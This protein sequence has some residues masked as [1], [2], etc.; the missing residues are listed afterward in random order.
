MRPRRAP[1]IVRFAWPRLWRATTAL[2]LVEGTGIDA[3]ASMF[4]QRRK[5]DLARSMRNADPVLHQTLMEERDKNIARRTELHKML[6]AED[7]KRQV[8]AEVKKAKEAIAKAAADERRAKR[9]RLEEI[10]LGTDRHWQAEDFGLAASFT[11]EHRANIR[12]ALRRLQ[13][14]SPTLPEEVQAVWKRFLEEWPQRVREKRGIGAGQYLL[15]R[16]ECVLDELGQHAVQNPALDTKKPR[17]SNP[18]NAKAFE[19]FVREE[20]KMKPNA[21]VCF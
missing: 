1:T 13:M 3:S 2:S 4:L 10:D 19:T 8:A 21:A 7:R 18:G 12:L 16:F 14:R 5:H 6:R 9:K 17:S 11:A 15:R 20:M